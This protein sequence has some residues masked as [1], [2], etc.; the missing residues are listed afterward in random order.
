MRVYDLQFGSRGLS[1]LHFTPVDQLLR[2]KRQRENFV[3]MGDFSVSAKLPPAP[4]PVSWDDI[5]AGATGLEI[6][7]EDDRLSDRW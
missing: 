4:D 5:L 2:L 1:F 6:S 3:N 7:P